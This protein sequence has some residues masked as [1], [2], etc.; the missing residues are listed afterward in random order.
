M[1]DLRRR[2]KV[3]RLGLCGVS[4]PKFPGDPLPVPPVVIDLG[5]RQHLQNVIGNVYSGLNLEM[6]T[7]PADDVVLPTAYL[8]ALQQFRKGDVA[9]IFTPDDTHFD[10]ALACVRRGL[11]VMVTKPIV[12]TLEHHRILHEEAQKNGVLVAVE[13]H[14]RWDPIYGDAHD[15]IQNLGPFSYLYSY[16]SQPKHQLDTFR[17]WAGKSS[18]ISY[19]LNSHHI[20]F[21]EWCVEGSSR[22]VR[23]VACGSTGVAKERFQIDTEDTITLT[24]QWENLSA[25]AEAPG[26]GVVPSSLGTA[27][28]TSSWIAPPSDVHSQ[29]RFFYMGQ[30]CPL[31]LPSSRE[32]SERRG[33]CGPSPP[34]LLCLSRW[35]RLSKRQPS[36]HEI[37]PHQRHVQWS[38]R[39]WL[40]VLP[41]LPSFTV[42]SIASPGLPFSDPLRRFS[43]P[44]F[45]TT[46]DS[47]LWSPLITSSPQSGL[48][49]APLQSWRQDA[50]VWM[51]E[52]DQW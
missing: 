39:L 50:E 14:K 24:V 46:T 48:P 31:L 38:T 36:L 28:Y 11:H 15:R 7:F 2:N 19:Y 16:M 33:D 20:D 42:I 40:Q 9:T 4:G 27:V 37:H 30:V 49:T 22:P 43:R 23:V 25:S 17:A 5:I 35:N 29:Q 47:P 13:V 21:H 18:D 52:G 45:K 44:A 10:I 1:F 32:L 3:N 12:M 26:S 41:P 34:R 6:E 8:E 51:R